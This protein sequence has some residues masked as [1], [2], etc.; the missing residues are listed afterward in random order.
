MKKETWVAVSGGFDPLHIG[1]VRMMQSAR[2]LGD[3]L[4]I[5][6]NNDNWLRKK[7]KFVFMPQGERAELIRLFPFVD[8]IILTDHKPNDPDMSVARSLR[9]L[10]PAVFANGGD[11]TKANTPE[12]AVCKELGIKRAY[13]VGGGKVQSSSWM[14]NNAACE[15]VTT[16]RPWGEF[17]DLADG[18]SWHLK[19]ITVLPGGRLS[20]QRHKHRSELWVLVE[21]DATAEIEK[22]GKMRRFSLKKFGSFEVPRRVK[23][24]LSSK[25]GGVLV[26]IARGA[27]DESDIE[28]FRDDY[29]RHR[30]Q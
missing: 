1:H 23:H 24:R 14:I 2:R 9:K 28:R 25:N 20:L 3:R 17:L 11:R 29:G 18:S 7:K 13:R 16:R 22:G 15:R 30:S 26:E 5:I 19:T 27:F 8:K 6:V 12:D 4:A 10:R 21:G